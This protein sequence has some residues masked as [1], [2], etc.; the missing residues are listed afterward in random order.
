MKDI[1]QNQVLRI[2]SDMKDAVRSDRSIDSRDSIELL[3]QIRTLGRAVRKDEIET[4]VAEMVMRACCRE[5][6]LRNFA[7]RLAQYFPELAPIVQGQT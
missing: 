6:S 1:D 3:H 2:I 7:Q 5:E 4:S